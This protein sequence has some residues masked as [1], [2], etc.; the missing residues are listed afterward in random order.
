MDYTFQRWADSGN[1]AQ[2]CGNDVMT[3][4]GLDDLC[5][6]LDTW[7]DTVGRYDD[8]NCAYFVVWKG[9]HRDV[10]DL[11]PDWLLKFGPRGGIRRE[12]C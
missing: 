5:E 12:P 11:Y 10:T 2:P 4:H 7:A 3:A 1:W 9:Y 8:R 6:C